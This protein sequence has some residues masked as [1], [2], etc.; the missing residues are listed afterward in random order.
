[1]EA[2]NASGGQGDPEHHFEQRLTKPGTD[3]SAVQG[4][5]GVSAQA[6][7]LW[8]GLDLPELETPGSL[9]R[10]TGGAIGGTSKPSFDKLPP[11]AQERL[12]QAVNVA[13]FMLS[14]Q[15]ATVDQIRSLAGDLVK[16]EFGLELDPEGKAS[17]TLDQTPPVAVSR[18][19]TPI[20][21]S[22]VTPETI[23]R[24]KT[25]LA[26]PSVASVLG[27][28]GGHA[29]FAQDSLTR[30]GY[31]LSV[32]SAAAGFPQDIHLVPG[33]S[34]S[35]PLDQVP[36]EI[37]GFFTEVSR[38]V[39]RSTRVLTGETTQT[40]NVVL[41]VPEAPAEGK[42]E[43]VYLNDNLFMLYDRGAGAWT[44]RYADKGAPKISLEQLND[45]NRAARLEADVQA[46]IHGPNA[47]TIH[48]PWWMPA[49]RGILSRLHERPSWMDGKTGTITGG[50]GNDTLQSG[51]DNLGLST[52]APVGSPVPRPDTSGPL[53]RE[54]HSAIR[55]AEDK[56]VSTMVGRGVVSP[57]AALTATGDDLSAKTMAA[58]SATRTQGGWLD[59]RTKPW[60]QRFMTAVSDIL[61]D[62]EGRTSLA[63]SDF[64]GRRWVK[65]SQGNPTVGVGFNL[66]RPDAR[67]LL[68]KVG[69]DYDAVKAGDAG[70]SRKQQDDLLTL[71][72]TKTANWLRDHF[73]GVDM[74]NHR[75][76]AL[77]SVAFNS[78]WGDHGPTIIGPKLT[79]AVR[80]GRWEDAAREIE[81]SIGGVP[82]RLKAG[83]AA[84]RRVEANLFRGVFAP[85]PNG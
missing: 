64:T 70:L 58:L 39:K 17:I 14:T 77:V 66:N 62:F 16:G 50:E 82:P 54:E 46:S 83:I 9:S 6:R 13:S 55:D 25:A 45:A 19:G 72:V 1:L 22:R 38:D 43:R 52:R 23:E 20:P 60:G 68:V 81:T 15:S 85:S 71:T 44:M 63:Y 29:G 79:A 35:V 11:V 5:G 56:A 21:G 41:R 24:A 61:E 76:Q 57:D 18:D 67:E 51:S 75:W 31:G 7:Q 32:R 26:D 73:K 2:L 37:G 36:S 80:E 42:D 59:D 47:D 33:Q 84:R 53:S 12:M 34:F 3:T 28:I 30:A 27:A 49:R 4:R 78:R 69:A 10:L 65:G 48:A 74:P 8:A 40:G